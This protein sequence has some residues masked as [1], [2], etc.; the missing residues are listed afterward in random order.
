MNL[1]T[2]SLVSTKPLPMSYPINT[3]RFVCLFTFLR[4]EGDRKSTR[5]NSSHLGIS[6]AVFCLKI[7]QNGEITVMTLDH[8]TR[9]ELEVAVIRCLVE[10]LR[11]RTLGQKLDRS[12]LAHFCRNCLPNRLRV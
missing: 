7:K 6:Y 10:H 3:C 11:S 8:S 4:I 2:A 12:N 9:M 5:L 1:I